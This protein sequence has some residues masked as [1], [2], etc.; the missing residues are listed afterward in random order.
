MHARL[1]L[2]ISLMTLS[3]GLS[4]ADK[5][6]PQPPPAGACAA[7]ANGVQAASCAATAAPILMVSI[8]S[9]TT[10]VPTSPV[11]TAEVAAVDEVPYQSL[12]DRSPLMR[13]IAWYCG[14]MA[15]FALMILTGI[16]VFEYGKRRKKPGGY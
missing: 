9:A 11:P 14:A 3:I 1:F 8:Q 6:V 13:M 10:P 5:P 7:K 16:T 2:G 4:A 15:P 12:F